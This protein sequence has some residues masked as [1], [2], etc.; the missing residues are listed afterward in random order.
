[1]PPSGSSPGRGCEQTGC[2]EG[3]I[4]PPPLQGNTPRRPRHEQPRQVGS[5]G[6][7]QPWPRAVTVGIWA[8][9][10]QGKGLP[11]C[12]RAVN[13]GVHD[14]IQVQCD[15][16]PGILPGFSSFV[17]GGMAFA[18][19][20][21]DRKRDEQRIAFGTNER[22]RGFLHLAGTGSV[23]GPHCVSERN[24]SPSVRGPVMTT[25]GISVAESL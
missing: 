4:P 2:P 9:T 16:I 21:A 23:A 24:V 17:G 19:P 12:P 10:A 5:P 3:V 1:G 8:E 22:P 20:G 6:C 25:A 18:P 11:S 14:P 13:F 15:P 7:R